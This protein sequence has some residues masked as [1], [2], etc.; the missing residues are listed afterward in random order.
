[1]MRPSQP[2]GNFGR[3]AVTVSAGGTVP[4]NKQGPPSEF[5]QLWVLRGVPSRGSGRSE[6]YSE[7]TGCEAQVTLHLFLRCRTGRER[8][9]AGAAGRERVAAVENTPIETHDERK[10]SIKNIRK[11]HRASVSSVCVLTNQLQ[12]A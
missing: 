6:H 10:R 5:G 7:G 12:T 9:R 2:I 4:K 8:G 3:K 1:M 11:W